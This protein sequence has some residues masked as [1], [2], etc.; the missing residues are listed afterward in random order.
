MTEDATESVR[1]RYRPDRV[2][3]LLV[4]ESAPARGQF[5]YRANSLLYRAT[6]D[7]F[8]RV[9]ESS[10]CSGYEFLRFFQSLGCYLDDLCLHPVNGLA[11]SERVKA[12]QVAVQSLADRIGSYAPPA[13]ASVMYE[14]HDHVRQAA[15]LAG[16]EHGVAASLPFPMG[17]NIHAY[18]DELAGLLRRLVDDGVLPRGVD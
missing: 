18:R 13:I 15:S 4:G 11:W 14:I 16:I 7:A 10:L 17:R 3:L 9:Y 5:F 2:R 1:R 8:T 12:R 6:R